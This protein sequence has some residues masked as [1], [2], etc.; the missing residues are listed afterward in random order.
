MATTLS[1]TSCSKFK[2][3]GRR[4]RDTPVANARAICEVVM[5]LP[6]KAA[7]AFRKE[8]ASILV[9]YLGGILR[10]AKRSQR[11]ACHRS[12]SPIWTQCGSSGRRWSRRP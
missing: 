7:A 8:T 5:L 6:G 11:T 1:A 9:R 4:Q 10:F 12:A 3:P 2:F